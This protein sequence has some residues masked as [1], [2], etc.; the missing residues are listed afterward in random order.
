MTAYREVYEIPG[1][2]SFFTKV[3]KTNETTNENEW[4]KAPDTDAS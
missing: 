1:R 3:R 2:I 4:V